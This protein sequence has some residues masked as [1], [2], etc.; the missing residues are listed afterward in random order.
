[1]YAGADA[2]AQVEEVLDQLGAPGPALEAVA[3][4]G[5]AYF[6]AG[7]AAWEASA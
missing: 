3:E 7:G 2:V 4:D 5:H 1:M 6:G